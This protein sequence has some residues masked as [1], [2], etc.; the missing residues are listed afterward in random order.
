M[1]STTVGLLCDTNDLNSTNEKL[2]LNCKN[3]L[4][5][6]L[7]WA[8]YLSLPHVL[9]NVP[10]KNYVNFSKI[11][12]QL[13]HHKEKYTKIWLNFPLMYKDNKSSWEIYNKIRLLTNSKLLFK[14]ALELTLN[15]P[16]NIN[17]YKQW[18]SE[19]LK[20]IIIPMDLFII[21]KDGLPELT[22]KHLSYLEYALQFKNVTITIKGDFE[23]KEDK[24]YLDY[25]R[26]VHKYM[27][28]ISDE[29]YKSKNYFDVLQ[30]PLQ[31]LRDNLESQT[32]EVF[33]DDPYKYI[34]YEKAIKKAMEFKVKQLK[35]TSIVL[36]VVGAGR[37][38]LVKISYKLSKSIKGNFK[39]FAIEKNTNAII[40]LNKYNEELWNEEITIINSDMRD[41]KLKIKCDIMISELLGSF[42]DNEL[43]PECIDGAQEYLKP[44]GINIPKN[45]TSYLAPLQSGNFH[46]QVRLTAG[47]SLSNYEIPYVVRIHKGF[48]LS[49]P[50]QCFKFSHP[51]RSTKNEH[52]TNDKY[53]ILKFKVIETGIVHGFIGYF[54]S[55]LYDNV[56]MSILPSTKS[57]G[58]LSWFPIVFPLKIPINVK[59]NSTIEVHFWRCS[60]KYKVW[61]EWCVTSPIT[62][63]IH[64]VNGESNFI[65]L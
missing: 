37:G 42:G 40:I 7:E 4:K 8:N 27:N 63:S 64:N 21:G 29:D 2:R 58:M 25:I 30:R 33:E 44:K 57:K 47:S 54:E 45:Y 18:F 10:K 41:L 48:N 17:L 36:F 15:L 9:I 22:P 13:Y 61:Y 32:Y 6:E 24:I 3:Q 1:S 23:S 39:I 46:N 50:Q 43:S 56:L 14:I 59:K 11:I 62:T 51:N 20:V 19:N 12:N 26:A 60:S 31:P 55:I 65:G 16:D 34:L 52:F 35:S 49:D 5:R 38:P 28:P 53:K